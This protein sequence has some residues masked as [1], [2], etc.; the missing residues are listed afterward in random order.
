MIIIK[1][2]HTNSQLKEVNGFKTLQRIETK[3]R[4]VS[5]NTAK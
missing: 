4:T 5:K 1:K 3:E 2:R